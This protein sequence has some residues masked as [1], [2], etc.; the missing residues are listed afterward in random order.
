MFQGDETAVRVNN[1]NYTWQSLTEG[2][3]TLPCDS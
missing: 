1:R 2:G 3:K